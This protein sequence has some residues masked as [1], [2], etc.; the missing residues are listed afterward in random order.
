MLRGHAE[1]SVAADVN[2]EAQRS[3]GQKQGSRR[4]SHEF[5]RTFAALFFTT[6]L[7]DDYHTQFDNPDRIDYAK[8]TRMT[9][10]MY[11]TGWLAANADDRPTIDPGFQLERTR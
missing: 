6:L 10:W 2:G 11:A 3:Q 7:H 8:L 1:S 9:S 5:R 4:P